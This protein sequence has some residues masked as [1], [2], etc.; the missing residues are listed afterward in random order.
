MPLAYLLFWYFGNLFWTLIVCSAAVIGN[1][2]D[3]ETIRRSTHGRKDT[4]PKK[5]SSEDEEE[6][7]LE[8]AYPQNEIR[9]DNA[10]NL[11]E[12]QT[13]E[14][15]NEESS[16]TPLLQDFNEEIM[17]EGNDP[18]NN[19]NEEIVSNVSS[20][21]TPDQKAVNLAQRNMTEAVKVNILCQTS[22]RTS[23]P[24]FAQLCTSE[25]HRHDHQHKMGCHDSFRSQSFKSVTVFHR[26][27]KRIV[28]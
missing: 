22:C 16:R 10:E 26:S 9:E 14:D 17:M 5:Q 18:Q 1:L 27:G 12:T 19:T 2:M 20:P 15:F 6:M 21:D 3:S 7:A 11:N 23:F 8:E 24:V 25:Q 4:F 13:F 28:F